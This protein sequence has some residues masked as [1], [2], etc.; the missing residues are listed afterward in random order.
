MII[1]NTSSLNKVSLALISIINHFCFFTRGATAFVADL[2]R[3]QP[4][5]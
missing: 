5:F 2:I 4:E 3:M 1:I